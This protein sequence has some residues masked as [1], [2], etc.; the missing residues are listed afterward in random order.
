MKARFLILVLFMIYCSGC[1]SIISGNQQEISVTSS[2]SGATVTCANG[3]IIQTPGTVTLSTKKV[4]A[5]VAKYPNCEPQQVML[6]KKLNNW[7]FCGILWDFGI[8]TIPIDLISGAACELEPKDVHFSF[9]HAERKKPKGYSGTID[10]ATGKP[11]TTPIYEK[12]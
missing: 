7:I 9:E 2:P 5:L 12:E 1:A 8:I 6:R 11:V 4:H 10:S 3:N